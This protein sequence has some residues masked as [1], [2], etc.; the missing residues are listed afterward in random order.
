MKKSF[1]K[2]KSALI[3]SARKSSKRLKSQQRQRL[4]ALPGPQNSAVTG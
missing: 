2:I 1:A 4:T 3:T